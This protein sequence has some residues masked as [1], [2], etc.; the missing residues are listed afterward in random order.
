MA[1][2]PEPTRIRE[3]GG[4]RY[5]E[6]NWK[7]R[8]NPIVIRVHIQ[9]ILMDHGPGVKRQGAVPPLP[10]RLREIFLNAEP[11]QEV[12]HPDIMA[13]ADAIPEG[14]DVEETVQAILDTVT[15]ALSYGGYDAE[16][17]GAVNAL[18]AGKG[19]CTEYTDLFVALCRRKGI[20]AR[21]RMCLLDPALG[22]PLH[23]VAEVYLPERGWVTYDPLRADRRPW[24]FRSQPMRVLYLSNLRNDLIMSGHFSDKAYTIY[25]TRKP[26]DFT[27]RLEVS[28]PDR[29]EIRREYRY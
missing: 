10:V 19:D 28:D 20:P 26:G 24:L 7:G 15:G 12:L 5:A 8:E 2:E 17:Q 16:D 25:D 3:S 6:W 23:T 21:S 9:A 1:F 29:P 27:T 18:A 13:L 22:V 4:R 11:F 14:G